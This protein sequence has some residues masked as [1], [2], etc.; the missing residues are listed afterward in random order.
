MTKPL[1]FYT[2]YGPGTRGIL[3]EIQ[4]EYG[5]QLQGI[6]V[7]EKLYLIQEIAKSLSMRASGEIRSEIHWLQNHIIKDLDDGDKEGLIEALIA[8]VRSC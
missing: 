5:S 7:R 4:E 3:H 1:G 2:S 6:S 8:Q